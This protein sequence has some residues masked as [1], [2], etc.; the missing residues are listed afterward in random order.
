MIVVEL[1]FLFYRVPKMMGRLARERGRSAWR[2]SLL[3]IGAWLGAEFAVILLGG[4]I[5]AFG[6]ALLGWPSPMDP[7]FKLV[8][9]I[10]AL[11]AALLST[12]IVA[13][14]LRSTSTE[15]PAPPPPPEF[16]P[17]SEGAN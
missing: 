12:T 13:R 4:I 10:L 1:Y 6:E 2:W 8:N 7:G 3:G 14:I 17:E 16:F 5:Y 9:Y 11:V 15:Q